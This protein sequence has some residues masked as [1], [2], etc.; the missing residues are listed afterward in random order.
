MHTE[1]MDLSFHCVCSLTYHLQLMLNTDLSPRLFALFSLQQTVNH[2]FPGA[3]FL[4]TEDGE[5]ERRR[6]KSAPLPAELSTEKGRERE[7]EEEAK[8]RER[9]QEGERGAGEN[10]R[11]MLSGLRGQHVLH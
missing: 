1:Y 6:S 2:G 3:S 10:S 4:L 7:E 5:R 11:W 8:E 9:V